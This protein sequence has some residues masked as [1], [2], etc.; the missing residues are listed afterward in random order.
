MRF[1]R[2]C[3][4][5]RRRTRRLDSEAMITLTDSFRCGSFTVYR[6]VIHQSGRRQYTNGFYIVADAARLAHDD[7]GGPA[8]DLLC[9]R[10]PPGTVTDRSGGYLTLTTEWGFSNDDSAMLLDAIRRA[11]PTSE[12]IA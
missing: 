1:A 2:P 6:D 9:Y 12:E 10:T 3:G 5:N 7:R 4:L 11:V 8:V